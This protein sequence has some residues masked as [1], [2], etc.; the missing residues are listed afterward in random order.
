M[1]KRQNEARAQWQSPAN[2]EI[3]WLDLGDDSVAFHRPS[4]KTHFLNSSS[5]RLITELLRDPM[6][7][8][9]IMEALGVANTESENMGHIESMLERLERLGLVERL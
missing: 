5:K 1:A 9:D 2:E 3:V 4:G 7:L 6:S 8:T